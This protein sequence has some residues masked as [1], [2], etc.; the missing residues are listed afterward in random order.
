[1]HKHFIFTL[2]LILSICKD[3][4]AQSDYKF[5]LEQ[6]IPGG[7]EYSKYTPRIPKRFQWNGNSLAEI[8]N[9][10]VWI[11]DDPGKFN[12]KSY[13]LSYS[14]IQEKL[15]GSE[16]II[17]SI[18]FSPEGG[19]LAR[20]Y[21]G[22]GTGTYDYNHKTVNTPSRVKITLYR[23]ITNYWLIQKGIIS[24]FWIITKTKSR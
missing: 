7:N 14:D 24:I 22:N 18:S 3:I 16:N 10:S 4:S 9:D 19:S 6:L 13:L 15:K 1:M 17:N 21:T 5:T 11:Y 20:F 2:F 8:E 12:E 23:Q